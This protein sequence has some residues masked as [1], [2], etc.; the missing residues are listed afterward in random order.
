MKN[1]NFFKGSVLLLATL[2]V[3]SSC[4]DLSVENTNDPN[5]ESALANDADL[6]SLLQGSTGD[7]FFEITNLWGSNMNAYSDQMTTTNMVFSW[8]V[9]TDEPRREMPNFPGFADL[10][11]NSGIWSSFNAGVQ[12]ANTII[13]LIEVDGET[14]VVDEADITDKMLASAYFLRGVSK[15]YLGLIYDQGY[16]IYPDTDLSNLELVPYTTLIENGIADIVNAVSI[17]DATPG[18]TW[19]LIPTQD[20]WSQAEF[21]TIAHSL[22][23]RILANSPRTASEADALDWS[24]NPGGVL[25]F[26]NRAVGGPDAA[27]TM[28]DFTATAVGSYVFYNNLLDWHTYLLSGPAGYLPPDIKIIWTLD[29]N[30]YTEHPGDPANVTAN[31][32]QTNDPRIDYYGFTNDGGFIS[33]ARNA[34]LFTNYF[35][36]REWAEN[37]WGGTGDPIPYYIAAETDYLRAEA[38]LRAGDKVTAGL[39]LDDSPY[40]NGVTDITPDLPAVTLGYIPADGFSGGNDLLTAVNSDAEFQ[41]ALL[42]EYSVEISNLGGIG[43]QWYFMRRWDMLQAGTPLH[44]PIPANELEITGITP[45]TFGGAA[46]AGQDGAASG[47]N[48]WKDLGAQ[49][50]ANAAKFN[51]SDIIVPGTREDVNF[52]VRVNNTSK[53]A[54]DGRTRGIE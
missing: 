1:I 33:A 31:E 14:I 30:Y 39:I 34:D 19:D 42:R 20:S 40:G 37:N 21:N 49:L 27:A 35:F 10:A 32:V 47:A 26:A 51:A 53:V 12:T 43:I 8:W 18:F 24:A 9:F 41:Y 25:Y 45:Y 23:A 46:N 22:A 52:N 13:E 4:A 15:G 44:Y 5:R 36:L 29:S 50:K 28:E 11:V 7:V 54:G 16:D 48:S 2:F 17:S 38:H 3:V 6:V